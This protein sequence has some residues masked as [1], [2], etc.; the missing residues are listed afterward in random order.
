MSNRNILSVCGMVLIF[1]WIIYSVLSS[2]S[3]KPIAQSGEVYL[4]VKKSKLQV[5]GSRSTKQTV[6]SFTFNGVD[7]I[8]ITIYEG[9][10]LSCNWKN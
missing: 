6:F 2:T 4:P 8:G 10:G 1:S 3:L 9:G 7:C 5:Y